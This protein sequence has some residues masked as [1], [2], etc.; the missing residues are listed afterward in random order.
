MQCSGASISQLP[1]SVNVPGC[2][3]PPGEL[4]NGR[5]FG[6]PRPYPIQRYDD[7]APKP[8]RVVGPASSDCHRPLFGCASGQQRR[9]LTP[10]GAN[11]R[12]AVSPSCPPPASTAPGDRSHRRSPGDQADVVRIG[13]PDQWKLTMGTR[14]CS[15]DGRTHSSFETD[16]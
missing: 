7:G 10:A 5:P 16:S 15:S 4:S 11:A 13:S 8:D 2:C 14:R 6:H 9:L 3:S 1:H 12:I